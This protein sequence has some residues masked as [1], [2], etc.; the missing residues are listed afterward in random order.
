MD[1]CPGALLSLFVREWFWPPQ[2]RHPHPWHTRFIDIP[3]RFSFIGKMSLRQ[4]DEAVNRFKNERRIKV[5]LSTVLSPLDRSCADLY[6]AVSMK[7]GGVG[8]NLTSANRVILLDLGKLPR[9]PSSK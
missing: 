3:G 7:A 8:L 1:V 9:C 6:F 4:R 2:V 5:M